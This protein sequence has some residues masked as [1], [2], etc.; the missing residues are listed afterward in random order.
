MFFKKNLSRASAVLY[1]FF[2]LIFQENNEKNDKAITTKQA[3]CCKQE[4]T[5][6][7]MYKINEGK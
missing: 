5:K 3:W 4:N 2:A 1:K 6:I 7:H